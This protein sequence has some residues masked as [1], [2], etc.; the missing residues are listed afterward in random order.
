MSN[1]LLQDKSFKSKKK[2]KLGPF[3]Y[4]VTKDALKSVSYKKL[5]G[6]VLEKKLKLGLVKTFLGLFQRQ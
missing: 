6:T 4:F 3:G 2:E 1:A 5:V